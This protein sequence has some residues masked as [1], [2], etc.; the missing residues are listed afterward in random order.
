MPLPPEVHRTTSVFLSA[1]DASAPGLVRGLYLC[2]SLGFGEF[3]PDRSDVDFVSVLAERPDRAALAAL[4]A[5]HETVRREHP[6][7]FFDGFHAVREDLVGP[8]E[9]CPDLPCTR[10]GVYEEA[11][12]FGINPVTWHELV[13]HG[14]KVRGPALTEAEVH[15]DD[16]ALRAFS[17]DNLSSYWSHVHREL[18]ESPA[19]AAEPDA[20]EWCV[21]GVSRLHHLLSTG[22]LTSKSGAGRYALNAFDAR[23]HPIVL[24]ALRVRE[25]TSAPSVYDAIPERRADDTIAFTAMVIGAG[26]AHGARRD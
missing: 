2:G 13:R 17:H 23:W 14:V 24:E 18:V 26:L 1:I 5:A 6:R 20:V 12:R 21:L 19:E 11:G 10:M 7:P 4:A 8:P 3:F 15:V 16:A 22:S 9:H 25:S